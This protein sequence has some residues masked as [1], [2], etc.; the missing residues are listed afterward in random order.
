VPEPVAP[1]HLWVPPRV[2]S[3]GDEAID[4]ARLAGKALNRELDPEQ[5]IAVDALLSYGPGGRWVSFESAVVE[6][7]QNGKTEGVL[8]PVVL[9]DLFLLPPDRIVWTAHLFRTSR[10]TF[11]NFCAMIEGT[12]ELSRR[13]KTIIGERGSEVIELS[14]GA[15][16]EFLA[17]SRGGGRGLGGKRVVMDEALILSADM[18]DALIPTLSARADQQITYGSSAGLGTSEHLRNLRDRGR[19]GNDPSLT[20]VEWCSPGG[21]DDPPCEQGLKCSHAVGSAGCALDDESLW[22]HS[23]HSLGKVRKNGTGLTYAYVRNERRALTPAGF[24]RERLGWFD[25]P[26]H[27]DRP[28]PAAA[29]DA[30]MLTLAELPASPVFFLDCSPGMASASITGAAVHDGRPYLELADYRAGVDWLVARAVELRDKYPSARFAMLAS[31]AASALKPDMETAG[32]D[33]DE[34]SNQDM[35]RACAHLQKLVADGALAHSGDVQFARALDG[36]VKR[37]IGDDL[38]AWSRRKSADI[39]AIVSATGA[40]WLLETQPSYDLLNSI[41]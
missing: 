2:G 40:A 30:C 38:W 4:L 13:V 10:A 8:E 35:G 32:L 15:K 18:M 37:D 41:W 28:I 9:F 21:W 24:G 1:A 23:N 17:R 3:Y 11:M 31:G 33:V 27:V 12:A 19:A 16:L 5:E 25:L 14:S 34:L 6:G 36:A 29:W 26:E 39:T 22:P 7:R 20:W